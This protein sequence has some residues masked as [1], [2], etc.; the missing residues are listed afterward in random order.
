MVEN[1]YSLKIGVDEAGRGPLL[2][3]LVIGLA[4]I[5]SVNENILSEHGIRDSK[6]LSYTQRKKLVKHIIDNSI[7]TATTYIPPLIID[8]H[9]LNK[10]IA[11]KIVFLINMVLSIISRMMKNKCFVEIIIDDIKGYDYMIK[12]S[13]KKPLNLEIL[14]KIEEKADKKHIIVSAASILAKF[15]RDENLYVSK[16]IFGEFGSG[17]P[18]DKRTREWIKKYYN[19]YR[20]PPLIIRRSWTTLLSLAPQWYRDLKK[21]R[22]ILDFIRRRG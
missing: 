7:I 15:Y 19:T 8:K 20:E 12:R 3:D 18:S 21:G 13:I 9:K 11:N 17:Y 16:K 1:I 10:L 14:V 2:G 6:E 4:V 5:N 22:S